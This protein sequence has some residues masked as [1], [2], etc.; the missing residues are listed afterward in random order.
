MQEH[1]E[2]VL[3]PEI[4]AATGHICQPASL[5]L[6]FIIHGA[7]QIQ[8]MN[9][10]PITKKNFVEDSGAPNL[11]QSAKQVLTV[12]TGQVPAQ[13]KV[14]A[15]SVDPT[16]ATLTEGQRKAE[17]RALATAILEKLRGGGS[18]RDQKMRAAAEKAKKEK[19]ASSG[20]R[21][22]KKEK[23]PKLNASLRAQKE[24]EKE[25]LK[26]ARSVTQLRVDLHSYRM[27]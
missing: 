5:Q 15:M 17:E 9:F 12:L 27:W 6:S 16:M 26:S 1:F 7:S 3:R 19:N 22:K 21:K 14:D 20:G 18:K 24:K 13:L 10:A 2:R 11:V 4:L 25:A 23:T 8:T